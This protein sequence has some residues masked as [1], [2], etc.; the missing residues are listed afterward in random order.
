MLATLVEQH[1]DVVSRETLQMGICDLAT[2]ADFDRSLG[3][4]VN[5]LCEA[6]ED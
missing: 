1:G 6:L 4:T 5:K 2:T 3:I